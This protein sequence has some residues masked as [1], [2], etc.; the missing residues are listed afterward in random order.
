MINYI[1]LFVHV[2]LSSLSSTCAFVLFVHIV[3]RVAKRWP[4]RRTK[5][6]S[7][8]LRASVG[9]RRNLVYDTRRNIGTVLLAYRRVKRRNHQIDQVAARH[10]DRRFHRNRFPALRTTD[11]LLDRS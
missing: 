8:D 3:H 9:T 7:N 6:Q 5:L 2:S 4:R 10:V 1:A 11:L